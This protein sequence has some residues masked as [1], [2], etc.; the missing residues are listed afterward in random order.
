M[1]EGEIRNPINLNAD[2]KIYIKGITDQVITSL[3]TTLVEIRLGT[4]WVLHKVHVVP[5]DFEIPS[6][7][8]LGRDFLKRF[9]CNID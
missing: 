6:C 9:D 4:R 8:I 5:H 1:K 7:G 2:D 3:G